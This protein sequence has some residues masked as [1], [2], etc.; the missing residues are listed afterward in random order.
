M[1]ERLYDL[2]EE[3]WIPFRRR[4]GAVEWGAPWLLTDRLH[5]DPIVTLAAPRPDFN[6]ALHEFLIGLVSVAMQAQDEAEWR[7]WWKLP[8]TPEQLRERLMELPPAFYLNGDGPRFMQDLQV[9]DFEKEKDLPIEKLLIETGSGQDLFV[10]PGRFPSFGPE[11]TA[12]ALITLQLYSPEGGRGHLTGMRGGGPLTTLAVP[13]TGWSSRDKSALWQTLWANA[14]TLLEWDSLSQARSRSKASDI[15]PW[16]APTRKAGPK[17]ANASTPSDAHPAQCFFPM[18]RR[19]RVRFATRGICDVTGRSAS[20]RAT[21]FRRRPLGIKYRAW[22]HPLSPYGSVENDPLPQA[23]HGKADGVGWR[24]WIGLTMSSP[25]ESLRRPA[26]TISRFH[27]RRRLIPAPTLFSLHAFGFAMESAKAR[28]WV[29]SL[30]PCVSADDEERLHLIRDTATRLIGGTQ[31]AASS[32]RDAVKRAL[33]S[34][35]KSASG[36]RTADQVALWSAMERAFYDLLLQVASKDATVSAIDAGCEEF[37]AHLERATLECF[38]NCVNV[39]QLISTQVRRAVVAR[40]D[41]GAALRGHGKF[42]K[43]LFGELRLPIP[44]NKSSTAK[45]AGSGKKLRTRTG[46]K[47]S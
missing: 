19:I 46:A 4:S 32:L 23:R 43:K 30:L 15:F 41:L 24:D 35:A 44:E 21:H 28:Y 17:G 1:T 38:D 8:P 29:D 13:H 2:R 7:E 25:V 45:S 16:L 37:R 26:R 33:L 36:E 20:L 12:M 27:E 40:Y 10:R 39:V 5:D 6:G 11:A 14:E 3:P 47:A 22:I 34:N 18:P 31:I 42:G 9:A